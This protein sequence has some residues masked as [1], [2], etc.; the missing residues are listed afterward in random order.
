VNR[1]YS[2]VVCAGRI[3]RVTFA[4]LADADPLTAAGRILGATLTVED[5]AVRIVEVEAYGSEPDGPW[6][7]PAAHSFRGPTARTAVLFGPAGSLYVHRSYGMHTCLNVTCGP[8]GVAGAVLIRSGE[9]ILGE[10]AASARRPAARRPHD[11]ARGPGNLGSALG[12]TLGDYGSH[13][14][15]PDSRVRL[16][17]APT[18]TWASG[19]R[20]GVSTAPDRPWR[21]WLPESSAVSTYRRSPRA[22][23]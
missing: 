1:A 4:E 22:K 9:V 3:D 7:D 6:P 10:D 21:L 15:D 23:P 13:L 8:D 11:L 12:I 16:R 18:A 2:A 17:L 19:P 14:F 5:V 20:I